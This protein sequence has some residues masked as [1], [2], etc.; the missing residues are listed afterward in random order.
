MKLPD[1]EGKTPVFH[2]SS[3]NREQLDLTTDLKD[4]GHILQQQFEILE[5]SQFIGV[6]FASNKGQII[7]FLQFFPPK[8]QIYIATLIWYLIKIKW[9]CQASSRKIR[10][11]IEQYEYFKSPRVIQAGALL[12]GAVNF[13]LTV[14]AAFSAQLADT[15]DVIFAKVDVGT[16]GDTRIISTTNAEIREAFFVFFRIV[17][18]GH[19]LLLIFFAPI[20]SINR[21]RYVR[22]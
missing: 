9:K 2:G 5:I 1:Q 11:V 18:C 8:K 13:L 15:L 4:F 14:F 16:L 7:S 20:D 6:Q 12:F 22:I 3:M 17:S 19:I 21:R 10:L